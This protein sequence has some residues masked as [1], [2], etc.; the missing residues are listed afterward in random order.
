LW[1]AR[2][3][4]PGPGDGDA[5]GLLRGALA[6]QPRRA[7]VRLAG[8]LWYGAAAV[9]G[10]GAGAAVLVPLDEQWARLLAGGAGA[11]VTISAPEVKPVSTASAGDVPQLQQATQLAGAADVGPPGRVDVSIGPLTIPNLP[12]PVAGGAPLRARAIPIEG[13]EDAFVIVS[14][15][16][17]SV[18]HASAAFFWRAVAGLA[19]VL[20]A[21]L[22]LG[23][24]VGPVERPPHVPEELHAAAVRIEGGDFAARAP[25]LAGKLG[26]IAAALNRAAELAGPAQAARGAAPPAAAT[27]EWYQPGAPRA[28]AASLQDGPQAPAAPP[29]PPAA[30]AAPAPAVEVDEETHWQ[31]VFQDFLRTR[32]SCGEVAEGLSYER[33][34]QKLEANKAQLVSKYA[35]KSVRFQ[36]YVKD[37]KAALKATPVR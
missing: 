21:G 34:R 37:G 35:C 2:R 33:F 13:M 12:Q 28:L 32:A 36:V 4:E 8:G 14:I 23:F 10:D 29:P 27:G 6:G 30:A 11:D 26:T 25:P 24:L 9:A 16:A 17:A 15:P 22:V 1:L 19:L 18:V 20:A 31:Q 7:F 3:G 5:L